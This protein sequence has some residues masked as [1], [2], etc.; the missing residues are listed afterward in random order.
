MTTRTKH[1]PLGHHTKDDA[2][3]VMQVHVS[4]LGP[5]QG[6]YAPYWRPVGKPNQPVAG[7]ASSSSFRWCVSAVVVEDDDKDTPAAC[8]KHA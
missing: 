1:R 7:A 5:S 8:A 2:P 4:E 3:V 6:S